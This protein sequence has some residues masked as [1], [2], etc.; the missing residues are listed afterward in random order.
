MF[1]RCPLITITIMPEL[2]TENLILQ[3]SFE[4]VKVIVKDMFYRI[5]SVAN[6]VPSME[7]YM[8]PGRNSVL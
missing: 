7:Q 1:P 6:G 5:L 3:P 8:F 4:E 2:G